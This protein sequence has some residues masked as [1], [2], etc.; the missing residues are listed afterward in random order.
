MLKK[1]T[2]LKYSTDQ[3]I[4]IL[5]RY[6]FHTVKIKFTSLSY[7]LILTAIKRYSFKDYYFKLQ[8][9]FHFVIVTNIYNQEQRARWHYTT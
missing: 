6:A 8:F 7:T 3:A 5:Y 4:Y 9:R 1:L 2:F